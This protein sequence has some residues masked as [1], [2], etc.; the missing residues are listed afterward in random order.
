MYDE[1]SVED[2]VM[3][4]AMLFNRRGLVRRHDLLPMVFKTIE[5]NLI[6]LRAL[7]ARMMKSMLFRC[8]VVSRF[9]HIIGFH[10]DLFLPVTFFLKYCSCGSICLRLF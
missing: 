1:L 7:F 2:N 8:F 3:Y 9:Y 5:V 6:S 4:S 10:V